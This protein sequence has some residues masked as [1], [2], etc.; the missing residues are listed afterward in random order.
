[1]VKVAVW[2]PSRVHEIGAEKAQEAGIELSSFYG[3]LLSDCLLTSSGAKPTQVAEPA[4]PKHKT[5][6]NERAHS[7]TRRID[8]Y[9]HDSRAGY[10]LEEA[11]D[12]GFNVAS[13]FQGFP[14]FS[15][16]S[17]QA[18]VNEA[19]EIEKNVV[20]SKHASGI[21][22]KPNFVLI[23]ALLQ[24]QPGIRVSLWGKPEELSTTLRVSPG[25]WGY[26][27]TKVTSDEDLRALLPLVREAY[28]RRFRRVSR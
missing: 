27:R 8:R 7:G 2:L 11:P 19:I 14:A 24:R 13:K 20:V 3:T 4:Q 18:V 28:E 23:E 25:R 15:I 10:G 26:S 6:G 1:M 17:A 9:E 22:F 5:N 16:E 21:L 12:S